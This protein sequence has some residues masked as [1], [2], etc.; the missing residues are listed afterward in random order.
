MEKLIQN[1][2]LSYKKAD[3]TKL[4]KDMKNKNPYR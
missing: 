2:D 4:V 1:K 3:N